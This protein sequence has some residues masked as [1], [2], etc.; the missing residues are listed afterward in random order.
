MTVEMMRRVKMIA[1]R[2]EKEIRGESRVIG[3]LTF[4][5]AVCFLI[6]LAITVAA[7]F[8]IKPNDF[9]DMVPVGMSLGLVAWYFG[10]HKKHGIYME[11]FFLK[12]VHEWFARNGCRKYRT[13]NGYFELMNGEYAGMRAEN[14]R[15]KTKR[16]M[17]RRKEKK[18]K[19][20]MKG[21][22]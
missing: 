9:T 6:V 13:K 22:R 18:V 14:E 19:S 5:Q 2:I 10:F 3:K 17:M 7:Y 1:V 15:D 21:Y 12:K 20:R 8:V 11:Y 16:K 4:R